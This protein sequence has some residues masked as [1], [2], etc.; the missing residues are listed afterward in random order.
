MQVNDDFMNEVG[1]GEM[2]EAEKS[3]FM[4]HAQEEL[5]VRVGQ[6]L[7]EDLTREQMAEFLTIEDD[8]EARRWLNE[9][10][11]GVKEVVREV[12]EVFKREI[13]TQKDEIL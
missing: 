4:Q 1:L 13:K 2:P 8:D 6:R 5:E 11:P 3:V 7:S 9:K 10:V 12:F